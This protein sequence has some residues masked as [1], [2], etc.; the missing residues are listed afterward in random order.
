MSVVSVP[1]RLWRRRR[2]P[3]S[4]LRRCP[5][6][7]PHRS[8][9]SS[10]SVPEG[11]GRPSGPLRLPGIVVGLG[12]ATEVKSRRAQVAQAPTQAVTQA[13]GI[14]GRGSRARLGGTASF[15]EP[16][17]ALLVVEEAPAGSIQSADRIR[18]RINALRTLIDGTGC[19]IPRWLMI[20]RQ[21]GKR[22]GRFAKAGGLASLCGGA[23]RR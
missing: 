15:A 1:G 22:R 11:V 18:P 2:Y 3:T 16:S 4:S 8:L 17:L 7:R 19:V 20:R 6:R 5:T 12:P 13:G 23:E 10:G 14:A 9:A 21:H